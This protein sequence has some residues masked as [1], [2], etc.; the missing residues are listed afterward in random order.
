MF[1]S[2]ERIFRLLGLRYPPKDINAAWK[3]YRRRRPN[4]MAHAMEFLDNILDYDVKRF[5]LPLLED[6]G[7]DRQALLL[8]DI[9]PLSAEAAIR[10]L[11]R[12]GDDW[13]AACAVAAAGDLRLQEAESDIRALLER[14]VALLHPVAQQALTRLAAGDAA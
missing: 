7:M 3:A 6:D 2:V 1:R 4:Q 11:I 8:F 13:L 14:P 5:V 9:K 12:E 10:L